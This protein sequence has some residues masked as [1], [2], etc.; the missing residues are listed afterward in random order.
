MSKV[1]N[2]PINS[3]QQ[4][5]ALLI[6]SWWRHDLINKNADVSLHSL[7]TPYV[8]Q[9]VIAGLV[10][11]LFGSFSKELGVLS[12]NKT[13]NEIYYNQLIAEIESIQTWY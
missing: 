7:I 10:D 2:Q 1:F 9:L 3:K 4:Q 12:R 8:D 5:L 11:Q 6:V 13:D